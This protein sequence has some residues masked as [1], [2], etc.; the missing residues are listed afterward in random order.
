LLV[1]RGSGTLTLDL[2]DDFTTG[3][4]ASLA[5][6]DGT[7]RL[8]EG[9]GTLVLS[10]LDFGDL[11][12]LTGEPELDG[13]FGF[14]YASVATVPEPATMALAAFTLM[15]PVARRRWRARI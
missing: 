8:G 10:G 2:D 14:Y 6:V 3:P 9:G 13:V 11:G 1:K 12:Q 7:F 5:I 15:L 4:D